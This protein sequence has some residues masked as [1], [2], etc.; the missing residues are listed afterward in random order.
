MQAFHDNLVAAPDALATKSG[1][2][3]RV[4]TPFWKAASALGDP[5]EPLPAP[6]KLQAAGAQLRSIDLDALGLLPRRPDWSGGLRESWT[7]GASGAESLLSDVE[8]KLADY[9][10]H[11]DRP[12]IDATSRLSPHL[13]FGEISSRQVWHRIRQL[14]LHAGATAGAEALARQ[15]F[16]REFSAYLLYHFPLLPVEPLRPEFDYFPWSDNDDHLRAWQQGRTGFPIVDAGMRQLWH[17]GWM[18]NRVRMIVASFLVKDLMIPWQRGA[19]WF[20]DTLVDADLANNSAG[21]QWVA[22][23]GTDAAPYFRIFN[24]EV[25]ERKFDPEGDYVR[26]WVPDLGEDSYPQPI[27]DHRAARARA[28]EAYDSVRGIRTSKSAPQPGVSSSR[29]EP[30]WAAATRDAR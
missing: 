12:D 11:R 8:D 23:C 17:T 5:A 7:P 18:H 14:E 1:T 27:V 6:A 4:F 29:S 28:L 30:P 13:H 15:L 16:W 26:R 25:Q 21:W 10:R 2:C 19:E 20:L 22:G 3:Y 24:P 9:A